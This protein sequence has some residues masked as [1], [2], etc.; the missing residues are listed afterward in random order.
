MLLYSPVPTTGI[1]SSPA[2]AEW[3]GIGTVPVL[4]NSN[5]YSDILP[6]GFPLAYPDNPG[7]TSASFPGIYRP[8]GFLPYG[9]QEA[10]PGIS[11]SG[12]AA[13]VTEANNR[14]ALDLYGRLRQSGSGSNIFFSPFSISSALSITY[15]GARGATADEMRAVL[16]LPADDAARRQEY[17]GIFADLNSGNTGYTLHV[18]NALWAEKTYPFLPEFTGI[19]QQFYDAAAVNLD[20]IKQPEDSRVTINQ[21]VEGQTGGR[22]TDLVPSGAIDSLTRLVI[23]DAIYF[24]GTWVKQFDPGL[25]QDAEFRVS[26]LSSVPVRMMERTDKDAIYR[27]AETDTLQALEMPY[28]HRGGRALSMLVLLPKGDNLAQL[29]NSL[30]AESL[31]AL[32]AGLTEQRVLVYFPKFRLETEYSLADTLSAMGM[33]TAFTGAAD[34]SGMDGSRDLLVTGVYHKAFV[35]VDEQGTEAAA[36]TA[37]VIARGMAPQEETPPVFRADH[38]FIFLILDSET[39]NILFMGRVVDPG[40]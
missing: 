34:F 18:A 29:E 10:G 32:R 31:E 2:H 36:A 16:H 37:V 11:Q 23:T 28:A 3:P 38:P 12:P 40:G 39:G 13:T 21:W 1:P 14:F 26:S 35:E 27:Y 17:S 8:D 19:A 33:P 20:F 4:T 7:F 5:P 24:K 9:V 6:T 15:E 22:I 30:S 25:T